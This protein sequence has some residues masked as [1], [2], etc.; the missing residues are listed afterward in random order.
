MHLFIHFSD[1][2]I[3][4]RACALRDTAYAIIKEELDEDFEKLCEEIQESRKK[5]GRKWVRHQKRC[6]RYVEPSV[7]E[8][9]NSEGRSPLLKSTSL[10]QGCCS[11]KY[12]PSYYH[13]MP[14]PSSAAAGDRKPDVDQDEKPQPLTAPVAS[15]TPSKYSWLIFIFK[16]ETIISS[17]SIYFLYPFSLLIQ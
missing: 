3:R 2:L 14:K 8:M 16:I 12:A 13:V 5:R 6:F 10:L 4:H 7:A 11:S 17:N 9:C 1:R 15:S